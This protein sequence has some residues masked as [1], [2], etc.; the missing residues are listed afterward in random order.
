MAALCTHIRE[1]EEE[2]EERVGS[3][4]LENVMRILKYIYDRDNIETVKLDPSQTL[5]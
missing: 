3:T 1:E 2:E 5:I 4:K